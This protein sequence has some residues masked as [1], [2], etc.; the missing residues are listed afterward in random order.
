M[1]RPLRDLN[2]R[3][4]HWA[5]HVRPQRWAKHPLDKEERKNEKKN[6]LNA[7]EVITVNALC[8]LLSYLLTCIYL[9]TMNAKQGQ[10]TQTIVVFLMAAISNALGVKLVRL[11]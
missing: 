1:Q 5:N 8:K 4:A 7:L 11:D 6:R 10:M 3:V 9:L 2:V